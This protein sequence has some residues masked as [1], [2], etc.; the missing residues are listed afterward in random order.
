MIDKLFDEIWK[1]I[2][3]H[4]GETFYTITRLE[5]EYE[6]HENSFYPSRTNYQISKN[7]FFK[8]YKMLPLKGP[9]EISKII[10]GSSYVWAVL[11]DKR[12]S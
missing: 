1:R 3:N 5:F 8:A 7:D 11:N 2:K 9:G 6:V 12:I 4:T 10:R